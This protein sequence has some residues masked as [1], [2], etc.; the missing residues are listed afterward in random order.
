MADRVTTLRAPQRPPDLAELLACAGVQ[1]VVE[2]SSE[3]H[4]LDTFDGRIARR[5][6]QLTMRRT[7]PATA[8]QSAGGAVDAPGGVVVTLRAAP[9]SA[10]PSAVTVE[11]GLAEPPT[12]A[13]DFPNGPLRARIDELLDVRVVLPLL[14]FTA[15]RGEG[16]HRGDDGAGATRVTVTTLDELDV[17][18]SPG[19]GP[20]RSPNDGPP[21][22]SPAGSW[23]IVEER[24]GYEGAAADVLAALRAAGY[25]ESDVT[26][27]EAAAA[28]AGVD[29]AGTSIEPG[30]PL[31][32]R[33]SA[34]AGFRAVLQNLRDAIVANHDGAVGAV[35]PEF[36][37]DVR[38]AVRRSRAM[39]GAAGKVIDPDDRR[40]ARDAFAWFGRITGPARDLDV[41]QLEWPSFTAGLDAATATA[42]DPVRRDLADRRQVAHRELAT[43]LTSSRA[44]ELWQWW[45]RW[46]AAPPAGTEA[47]EQAADDAHPSKQAGD[48]A[49]AG[50]PVGTIARRRIRRAHRRML[51]RGRAIGPTTPAAELHAL[52]KDAKQLR[53]LI[54]CFGGLY[55]PAARRPFVQRLKTMQENLGEHQDAEVQALMLGELADQLGAQ[56]DVS[57]MLAIGRLIERLERRRRAARAAFAARFAAFDDATTAT[58]LERMLRSSPARRARSG[59]DDPDAAGGR[60]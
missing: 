56:L 44:T 60:R 32:P 22:S 48:R 41:Y 11:V 31:D 46:L 20:P 39:L 53:Y 16:V 2:D 4:V 36:L 49:D 23:V 51:E 59:D 5:G 7:V 54:E 35:D 47:A 6:Q 8:G 18:P 55:E 40:R 9:G 52:R 27:F 21:G 34:L 42:L 3:Y 58:A 33:T 13:A 37:H 29:L 38:V 1:P 15:R 10:R 12:V 28:V 24:R 14:V 17:G 26:V 43:A 25:D 19:V 30:I 45:D 50:R 57:S